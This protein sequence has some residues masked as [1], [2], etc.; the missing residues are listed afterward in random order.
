VLG[1][2]YVAAVV[3]LPIGRPY[4]PHRCFSFLSLLLF[5]FIG[6]FM[7]TSAWYRV[8]SKK[9]KKKGFRTVLGHGTCSCST[10]LVVCHGLF[11]HGYR[12]FTQVSYVTRLICTKLRLLSCRR[13]DPQRVMQMGLAD[14]LETMIAFL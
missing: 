1:R 12:V 11:N 6:S 5:T 8:I 10:L 2:I 3:A 13:Y 14:Y 9:K 4:I 7:S